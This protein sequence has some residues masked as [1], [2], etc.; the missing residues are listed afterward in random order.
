MKARELL[1]DN[2]PGWQKADPT[3]KYL[4]EVIHELQTK[5]ETLMGEVVVNTTARNIGK[6]ITPAGRFTSYARAA[7]G[8]NMSTYMIK[9]LIKDETNIEYYIDLDNT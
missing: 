7:T 8:N 3:I 2:T 9:K 4:I 1:N 5:V 6:Y